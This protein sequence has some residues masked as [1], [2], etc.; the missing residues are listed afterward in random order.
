MISTMPWQQVEARFKQIWGYDSFRPPQDDVIRTLLS[1]Q[2]ALIVM[3]TGGG[4]SICFQ[5]PALLQKGLTLVISPLVALME[6]QVQEL[7]QR[8]LAAE[9]IHSALAS[10][11]KKKILQQIQHNKLRLLY[12]SPETLLSRKVWDTLCQPQVMINGLILDEAHCLVQWGDTFRPTYRRLGAVRPTLLEHKPTGTQL[13]IA[14]FTATA[15]P[16]AQKTICDVLRLQQPQEVK[17][18]PY[19]DNLHLAVNVVWTPRGRRRAMLN[20]VKSHPGQAGLIYVRTRRTAEDLTHWLKP[21]GFSVAAYHAGL[22]STERRRIETEWLEGRCQFVVCTSAFGMGINHPTVRWVCHYH[23]PS[24]LSEYVQEIGR[25][26]RD[27]KPADALTLVS[28]PTGWLDSDDKQRW[29]FFAESER[30]LQ[31]EAKRLVKSQPA[32][33]NIDEVLKRDGKAATALALLHSQGRLIWQDPF[34]YQLQVG[35]AEKSGETFDN[36]KEIKQYLFS[37]KCRW[38]KLLV[39]FGCEVEAKGMQCGHCDNCRCSSIFKDRE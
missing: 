10:Y 31:R 38:Q 39:Q 33:G 13:P 15:N 27:G 14:A 7:K 37:R 34:H 24:T 2:D 20:F 21:K 16:V 28:E 3:P 5:L 35:Q 19:R 17:L 23:A 4:K 30:K 32:A 18:S 1:K 6:D 26:G 29:K 22:A 11:E 25:G 9:R 8:Q 12:L 36:V